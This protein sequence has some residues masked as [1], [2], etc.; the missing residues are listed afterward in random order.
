[1]LVLTGPFPVPSDVSGILC[2]LSS[3]FCW[4]YSSCTELG[5]VNMC[6]I[7]WKVLVVGSIQFS[8]KTNTY[9]LTYCDFCPFFFLSPFCIMCVFGSGVSVKGEGT[10]LFVYFMHAISSCMF[11]IYGSLAVYIAPRWQ[12]H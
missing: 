10:S 2:R 9:S 12:G 5:E 6:D 1:M 8:R 4:I 7:T 3:S 11:L